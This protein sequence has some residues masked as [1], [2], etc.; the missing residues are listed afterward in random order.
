[1]TYGEGGGD[2]LVIKT[3]LSGNV[4]WSKTYGGALY[5]GA[6]EIQSLS[7]GNFLIAGRT[8]SFGNGSSDAYLLK[9]NEIGDLLWS[10]T[11]GGTDFESAYSLTETSD[12]GI[13][14]IGQTKTF[15]AGK[16]DIFLVKTAADGYS[17]CNNEKVAATMNESQVIIAGNPALVVSSAP[18]TMVLTNT[19]VSS[20]LIISDPCIL[21]SENE[22]MINNELSVYPNPV[23]QKFTLEQSCP[24]KN[25][26]FSVIN[27]YGQCVSE[28][29]ITDQKSTF[30]ANPLPRG[31][32]LI[33]LKSERN[34]KVVK[35][36]KE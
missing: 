18:L 23:Q 8:E 14:L 5:D 13:M 2:L 35:F 12:D 15:G 19:T 10:K 16:A 31:F 20:G 29:I 36:F 28:Q 33:C 26:R 17:G 7:D 3:D 32:Y 24:V 21:T 11:Y 34:S 22:T 25:A 1:M 27:V 4:L 6:T 30:D 9:I